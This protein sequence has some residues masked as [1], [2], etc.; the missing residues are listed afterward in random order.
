MK[1]IFK[2][3]IV[4]SI[5]LFLLLFTYNL[6]FG[7]SIANIGFSYAIARGEIPYNDFNL[8]IPLFSPWVYAIPLLIFNSGITFYITQAIFLTI[9]Y[10]L[11]EKKL[12]YKIYLLCFLLFFTYPFVLPSGLYPGYNF[13]L[14]FLIFILSYIDKDNTNDYLI[15]FLI[16]LSIITKHTIGVFLVIPSIIFYYKDIKK[17]LKRLVGLLIPCFIFLIYLLITKSF[18][19]FLNLCVFGLFDFAKSNTYSSSP[20]IAV[21]FILFVVYFLYILKKNKNITYYYLFLTVLF[22]IPLFE[23]YHMSYFIISCLYVFIDRLNYDEKYKVITI[24]LFVLIIG[25]WTFI[26]NTVYNYK[27]IDYHNYPFRYSSKRMV[28]NYNYV[29]KIYKKYDNVTLFLIGSDNY[30]NKI[31]R[32]LDITYFDLPNYGN[33]GYDSFN[34]M[35]KKIDNNR[36]CYYVVSTITLKYYGRGQQYYKELANYIIDNGEFIESNGRY[37]VYYLE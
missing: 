23:S 25:L 10:Y 15:G 35:K 9:L 28:D 36:N 11:L 24:V 5:S 21:S 37:S 6:L 4:F 14:F 1:K 17:I 16:G 31:T 34:M 32:D 8:I 33:Y 3:L 12:K 26:M 20:F 7:D 18:F 22:V 29:S 27:Y 19:N 30:F 2:Y 13:I